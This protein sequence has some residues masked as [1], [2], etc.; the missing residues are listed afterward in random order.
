MGQ[1]LA[2]KPMSNRTNIILGGLIVGLILLDQLALHGT[3]TTFLVKKLLDLVEFLT[4]W[5]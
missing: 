3:G 2:P 4:F 5:R 1:S